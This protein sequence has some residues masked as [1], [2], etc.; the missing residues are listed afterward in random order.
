MQYNTGGFLRKSFI[1]D[2]I[3]ADE[4]EE[5]I[6]AAIAVSP[7]FKGMDVMEIASSLMEM[8]L[9]AER[10]YENAAMEGRRERR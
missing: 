10:Q 9:A 6:K 7:R 5:M 3:Y 2:G 1:M 4:A 8:G